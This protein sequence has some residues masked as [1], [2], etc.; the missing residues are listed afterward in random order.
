MLCAVCS[1]SGTLQRNIVIDVVTR[2]DTTLDF[3]TVQ[4]VQRRSDTT[5]IEVN[6]FYDDSVFSRAPRVHAMNNCRQVLLF[7]NTVQFFEGV[8]FW[9]FEQML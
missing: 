3:E 8:F 7:V 6:F 1:V 9:R 2:T 5:L 4:V